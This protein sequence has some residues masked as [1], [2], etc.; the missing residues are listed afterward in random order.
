MRILRVI[1]HN[2]LL[3]INA[4]FAG[5]IRDN[6]INLHSCVSRVNDL[7]RDAYGIGFTRKRRLSACQKANSLKRLSDRVIDRI[8]DSMHWA[9]RIDVIATTRYGDVCAR[10][11]S[12]LS[13]KL[14]FFLIAKKF[15]LTSNYFQLKLK[16]HLLWHDVKRRQDL[17]QFTHSYYTIT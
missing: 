13:W 4:C 12:I 9:I 3:K 5:S 1:S 8:R 7:D 11:F 10:Q 2:A 14:Q 15:A 16:Y 6:E 17:N